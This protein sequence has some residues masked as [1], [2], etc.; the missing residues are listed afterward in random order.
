MILFSFGVRDSSPL[1]EAQKI[2]VILNSASLFRISL[3]VNR[4]YFEGIASLCFIGDSG[5][6]FPA[7]IK[8]I[9]AKKFRNDKPE[10]L[11]RLT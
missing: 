4:R 11:M 1:G 3:I 9:P 2:L 6:F 5:Y 10:V 8:V 7:H